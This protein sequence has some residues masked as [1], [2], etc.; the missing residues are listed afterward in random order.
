MT[1]QEYVSGPKVAWI[2][3]RT[4]TREAMFLQDP[5]TGETR[6]WSYPTR[7]EAEGWLDELAGVKEPACG[8]PLNREWIDVVGMDADNYAKYCVVAP[9]I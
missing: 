3:V 2:F 6:P 8:F 4:D 5:E 1:E 7:E 9:L